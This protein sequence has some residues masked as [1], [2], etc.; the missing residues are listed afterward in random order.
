VL[1]ATRY[2]FATLLLLGLVFAFANHSEVSSR[3][4]KHEYRIPMRDGTHLFTAVYEPKDT[5]RKYPVLMTRT[6]YSVGPYGTDNYPDLLGP[7]PK[8]DED[9]FIYIFQDVRG[10]YM[11]EGKWLE[12]TPTQ[13]HSPGSAAVDESTDCYDTIEWLLHNVGTTNGKVGLLGISYPGF[14]TSAGM[15][16]SHPALVA[17]SPQAPVSDLFMGDDAYHNGA[18]FLLA[19]FTFYTD[20]GPQHNPQLPQPDNHFDYGTNDG[21]QYFLRMGSV[22]DSEKYFHE[23]NPYW[24]DTIRHWTYDEYW[25]PRNILPHLRSIRPAVLVTGG[26]FDA[27]DLSGTL[28]TYRALRGQSPETK[29]YFV[30]GPWWHGGWENRTATSLGSISFGSTT[31]A[32]FQDEIELPF[33]RHFLKGADDPGLPSAYMFETGRNTWKREDQWPPSGVEPQRFYLSANRKLTKQA[34]SETEAFDAYTS[35]PNHP[36]PFYPRPTLKANRDYMD[37]DQRFVSHRADVLSFE[38][39]PL[40][41]DLRVAGPVSAALHVS[42]SGTDSDYVV[43]LIDA[44]PDGAGNMSHYQELVRGEPFRAKFRKSFEHPE[45]MTPGQ[46]EPIQFQ[47]PDTDHVFL[48]GHRLMVQIQSTWFPLVD[49][50]PQIFADIPNAAPALFRAAEE[51]IY[52]S[53]DC[54]SYI[55]VLVDR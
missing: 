43:K 18:L 13:E 41:A 8:F 31:G 34:P 39:D 55:E 45:P 15:I 12:M 51:K 44:W 4:T 42:T 3:Y 25:K 14:Y 21:Y 29:T 2:A 32:F 10:R 52:R 53:R 37:G 28:K 26:W 9:G 16:D 46:V 36:V 54:P 33:F 24:T 20:F 11:S 22:G 30:M 48:K 23:Q 17:A 19:N 40:T 5:S 47:M 7:S 1:R 6:P 27:E 50:N 49:R 38:T 35:D